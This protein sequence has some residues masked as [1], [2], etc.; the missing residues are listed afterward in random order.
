MK[1]TADYL[2]ALRV[3]LAVPSDYALAE[4]L[5]MSKQHIHKFRKMHGSFSEEMSLRVADILEIDPAEIIL[6]MHYQREKNAAA[7]QVWERI[8]KSMTAVAAVLAIIA[9][10]PIISVGTFSPDLSYGFLG[11][12]SV[13]DLSAI[14]IM[15]TLPDAIIS[16]ACTTLA[17]YWWAFSALFAASLHFRP[18]HN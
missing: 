8:Y 13:S 12:T 11:L 17:A 18:R 2:D 15:R 10:M 3:R 14:Y 6:A 4:K 5:D 1:T 16:S 9:I 7:K